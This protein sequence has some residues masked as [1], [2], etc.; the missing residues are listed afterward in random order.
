MADDLLAVARDRARGNRFWQHLGIDVAE[1]REGWARLR[2]SVTD[3]LRNAPGAPVHGGVYA[4]LVDAAIGC[5]LATVSAESAGGVGQT[6]L[7]LN[8]TYLAAARGAAI[9][10]EGTLLRRGRTV[11]FGEVRIT[12]DAGTLLAVGRATYLILTPRA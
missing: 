5:A 9:Y 4:A 7:D 3:D 12:D 6:T 8:V 1:V 11:A 2:V 10:A